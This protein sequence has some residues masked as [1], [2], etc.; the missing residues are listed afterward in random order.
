MEMRRETVA[1]DQLGAGLEIIQ[2]HL[3]HD[4]G[5]AERTAAIPG[6]VELRHTAPLGLRSGGAVDQDALA[7][8]N[9]LHDSFVS[10]H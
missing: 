6:I 10:G 7:G 3:A 8:M 5:V 9:P 4:I 2:M 1:D